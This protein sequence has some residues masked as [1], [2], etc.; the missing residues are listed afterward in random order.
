LA[1]PRSFEKPEVLDRAMKL[2]WE[3][4]FAGTSM[5]ELAETTGLQP[6]SLYGTFENKET[7]FEE[8]LEHYTKT[9]IEPRLNILKTDKPI[10]QRIRKFL[11]DIADQ[12]LDSD[13]I[14]GCIL[15]NSTFEIPGF[16]SKRQKL[17]RERIVDLETQLISVLH[18]SRE[19]G[20][21]SPEANPQQLGRFFAGIVQ[22]INVLGR[23]VAKEQ[24]MQ[25]MIETAIETIHL[26]ARK[27]SP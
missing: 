6:G 22:G 16:D 9:V 19:N 8:V 23:S 1:R 10:K 5:S 15:T 24:R 25:A 26:E 11:W 2:F 14:P 20:E 13:K 4:G 18:E 17:I 7:L 12:S 21:L 3:K 27:D